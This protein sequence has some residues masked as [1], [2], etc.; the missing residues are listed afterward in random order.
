MKRYFNWY[1]RKLLATLSYARWLLFKPQPQYSEGARI[2]VRFRTA[3]YGA[4]E[5]L[6][7]VTEITYRFNTLT[8]DV[9][10]LEEKEWLAFGTRTFIY[11]EN[12]LRMQQPIG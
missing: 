8:Y 9:I 11:P 6:C 2:I 7:R 10:V 12:I 3:I 4:E 5:V 1:Y